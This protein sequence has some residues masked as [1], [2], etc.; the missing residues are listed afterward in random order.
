MKHLLRLFLIISAFIINNSVY[1]NKR[2]IALCTVATGKYA[3][4][5]KGFI[6]SARKY[7]LPDQNVKYFIFTDQILAIEGDDIV[8]IRWPHKKWPLSTLMRFK[9]YHENK[10]LFDNMDY[11]F[12]YDV[13]ALFVNNVGNEILGKSVGVLHPGYY[14][15]D[16]IGTNALNGLVEKNPHSSV[17]LHSKKASKQYFAGGFYGGQ[18]DVFKKLVSE[19]Y[20]TVTRDLQSGIVAVWHDETHLNYYFLN[21]PPEIKLSP[22][23]CYPEDGAINP[24][25]AHIKYEEPKIVVLNKIYSVMR[26]GEHYLGDREFVILIPSYNNLKYYKSNLNSVYKQNYKNFRVIYIDD[27]SPD[28]TGEAVEEYVRSLGK[29]HITT[30]VRNKER[31]LAMSNIY[32]NIHQYT[33]DHEIVVMLDGDD[34]L[35]NP[36]VLLRLNEE[37]KKNNIWFTYGN[38]WFSAVKQACP[39]SKEVPENQIELNTFRMWDGA[40]THLRTFYAWLFKKIKKTDLMLQGDFFKMTYDVAMFMPMLEMSGYHH[41]FIKDVLYV[42]NDENPLNDHKINN[43]LQSE[44]NRYIRSKLARYQPIT[45]L[46]YFDKIL[47]NEFDGN[48]IC[49]IE[50]AAILNDFIAD[51]SNIYSEEE[52]QFILNKIKLLQ[53]NFVKKFGLVSIAIE[54]SYTYLSNYLVKNHCFECASNIKEHNVGSNISLNKPIYYL[55]EILQDFELNDNKLKFTQWLGNLISKR[56]N[57]PV[58]TISE[59]VNRV[60]VN[61]VTPLITAASEGLPDMVLQL[62]A[63]GADKKFR[64]TKEGKRAV[65]FAR[66][67]SE[68]WY[69]E[70][71]AMVS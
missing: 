23:Y 70:I 66:G 1:A 31:K 50:L 48:K 13:D 7:F 59:D 3:C 32:N 40:A 2:N 18:T 46:E 20:F 69:E 38:C 67:R 5:V 58:K 34:E 26:S 45:K 4:F 24:N 55:K 61:G 25:Y 43:R 10:D 11:V 36:D 14:K 57:L 28:G 21:N 9:A 65:D 39:W 19:C 44:L 12:S 29:E 41:K 17:F 6:E 15:K 60:N 8:I 54:N 16:L 68:P 63:H 42:Y 35:A 33:M 30:I 49:L 51:I 56:Y 47:K 53:D 52:A 37:Y 27:C 62:L 64:S 71:I 22:A